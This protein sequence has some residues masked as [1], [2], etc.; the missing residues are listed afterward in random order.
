METRLQG[1]WKEKAEER[2]NSAT[3]TSN[4]GTTPATFTTVTNNT[5]LKTN[6]TDG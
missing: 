4:T 5:V 2:V 3:T 6:D 1:H